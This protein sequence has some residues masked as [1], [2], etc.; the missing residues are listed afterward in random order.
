MSQNKDT[1]SM[2][3][4]SG[5]GQLARSGP[6]RMAV[7][8]STTGASTASS[9][10]LARSAMLK[11]MTVDNST[12]TKVGT[13]NDWKLPTGRVMVI[14]CFQPSAVPASRSRTPCAVGSTPF[15]ARSGTASG[16]PSRK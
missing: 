13:S 2:P 6:N 4:A 7:I 9:P 14:S 3:M 11:P 8:S 12:S 15:S 16:T 1:T 10:N 5:T